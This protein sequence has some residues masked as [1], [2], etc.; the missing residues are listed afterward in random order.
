MIT[1]VID[2]VRPLVNEIL[3]VT[4]SEGNK[5]ELS[6]ILDSDVKLIL[7]ECDLKSPV[8]GALSGFKNTDGA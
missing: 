6:K 3:V 5:K 2:A 8:V 7:D 1:Y 4:D